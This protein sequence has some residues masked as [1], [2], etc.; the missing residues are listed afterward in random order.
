MGQRHSAYLDEVENEFDGCGSINT[1]NSKTYD[2]RLAELEA[3]IRDYYVAKG[4]KLDGTWG[5]HIS[6]NTGYKCKILT[7]YFF[8]EDPNLRE[9]VF[10]DSGL[11]TKRM[12]DK[13]FE[14]F[15]IKE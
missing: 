2:D 6:I 4:Y 8:V 11:T 10:T 13:A 15:T 3:V 7:V 5:F 14:F 9:I 12:F 1:A